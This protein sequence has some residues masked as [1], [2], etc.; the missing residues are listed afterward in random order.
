MLKL[1]L[2]LSGSPRSFLG[3]WIGW[4]K[5]N[6]KKIRER[7]GDRLHVVPCWEIW[8]ERNARFFLYK[9]W[10][11]NSVLQVSI[12]SFK[13]GR[14]YTHWILLHIIWSYVPNYNYCLHH[15]HISESQLKW[16]PLL[17]VFFLLLY[18]FALLRL[19][20]WFIETSCFYWLD[21]LYAKRWVREFI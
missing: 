2:K 5:K 13:I 18:L 21:Y 20:L 16:I 12:W 15:W 9:S 10:S 11:I 8:K 1:Q 4:K 19:L 17:C 3:L 6:K 7:C 14:Y